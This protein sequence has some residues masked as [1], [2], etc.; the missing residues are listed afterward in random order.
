MRVRN[1]LLFSILITNLFSDENIEMLLKQYRSESE[2]SKITEKESAGLVNI[3]TRDDLEKMQA[4]TLLDVL[5]TEVLCAY[6]GRYA[7]RVY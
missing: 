7:Y 1:F 6:L 5:K 2:L 4:H 3:F